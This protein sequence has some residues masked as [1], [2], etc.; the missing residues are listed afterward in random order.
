ME[1]PLHTLGYRVLNA[2][3]QAD[4]TDDPLHFSK[5]SRRGFLAIAASLSSCTVAD[6]EKPADNLST[7]T[8][9]N[10][11]YRTPTIAGAAPRNP[12]VSLKSD[13]SKNAGITFARV[14]CPG[15]YI[16]ITYDDGPHKIRRAC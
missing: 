10:T 9:S 12:G 8:V 11:A 2:S 7:K 3:L 1:T 14:R 6:A 15:N 13:F 4:G 16:A 5:F